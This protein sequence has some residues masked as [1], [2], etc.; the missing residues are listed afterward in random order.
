MPVILLRAGPSSTDARRADRA[1]AQ[2]KG[3]AERADTRVEVRTRDRKGLSEKL[4]Q[5]RKRIAE[6]ESDLARLE[7]RDPLTRSLLSL[8]AFRAQLELDVGR[9][10]RYG[11]PLTVALID[12]DGFRQL[13]LEHG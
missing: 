5:A 6:L 3:G 10:N 8:N 4:A 11:R 7:Q 13:N 9:A 12:I 2:F 1:Q